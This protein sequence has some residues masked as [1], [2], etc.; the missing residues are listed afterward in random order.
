[1]NPSSSLVI[2]GLILGGA[3]LCGAL[4]CSDSGSTGGS[5]GS[6]GAGAGGV[7]AGGGGAGGALT[8][9]TTSGGA[10]AGAGG[11]A[12]GAGAGAMGG[13]SG[14]GG[15]GGAGGA[16][17]AVPVA[18]QQFYGRWDLTHAGKAVT[19]NSGSHITAS[20][21][22]TGIS[23]KFDTSNNTGQI[24]TVT[25][26]IDGGDPIEK[27]IAPSLVLATGLSAGKHDLTLFVRGANEND[28]RWTPPLVAGLIFES[29]TVEGGSI[30]QTPRP[31]RLKL[32]IL[33]DSI[34]EGV[35]IHDKGPQGQTT[36][37]WMTDGPRGYAS[38]TAQA[39][40]AEWRQVGFGRQGLTIMG[41][42]GVP[43]AAEAFNWF[44]KGQARDDW[45]PDAVIINQGTNDRA[46]MGAA[47]AP[48]Y[49]SFLQLIRTAYPAAKIIALR[50]FVG[51]FGTEIQAQVKA[52]NDGGDKLVYYIDTAGWTA[53]ADFTDG[54]HPNVSGSVKI[55]DKLVAALTPILK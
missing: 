5:A 18:D 25:I 35:R 6:S 48:L 11:A 52:R 7:A 41:N 13:L 15:L 53:D 2:F 22:G 45:Q 20:F 1:M 33:G 23:A 28:E 10:G 46:T 21:N 55:K 42:G 31:Q 51:A 40:G 43:K 8:A 36:S 50:P 47:F 14:G 9:G 39:L 16:G 30:V 49:G 32:E 54:L 26:V 34:T 19:V 24:P 12:A 29:F 27:E 38:L 3:S 4:G 17:G 37:N 44:Y